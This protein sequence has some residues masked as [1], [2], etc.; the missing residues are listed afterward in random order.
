MRPA[1]DPTTSYVPTPL[2]M[3]RDLTPAQFAVALALNA[4]TKRPKRSPHVSHIELQRLQEIVGNHAGMQRGPLGPMRRDKLMSHIE[5][6]VRGN[7]LLWARREGSKLVWRWPPEDQDK[8][9]RR[10]HL[11]LGSNTCGGRDPFVR[12]PKAIAWDS[13]LT[14]SEKKVYGALHW[15]LFADGHQHWSERLTKGLT[16]LGKLTGLHRARVGE[17]LR[18]LEAKG[19]IALPPVG[20]RE[21]TEIDI[22]PLTV[23]Y[24]RLQRYSNDADLYIPMP[25]L[26]PEWEREHRLRVM[27]VRA[28]GLDLL[29]EAYWTV[30][31]TGDDFRLD[32]VSRVLEELGV[33]PEHPGTSIDGATAVEPPDEGRPHQTTRT[34][35][36]GDPG[37][38]TRRPTVPHE[39]TVLSSR[40]SP[41]T[42]VRTE[43]CSLSRATARRCNNP[44]ESDLEEPKEE[45]LDDDVEDQPE[46][47]AL[48]GEET[49]ASVHA[50]LDQWVAEDLRRQREAERRLRAHRPVL[51]HTP[52][53]APRLDDPDRP[54][55]DM[56][57]LRRLAST[58]E[59][60]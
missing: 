39:A 1:A 14:G 53:R 59:S 31:R 56:D 44:S 45:P 8:D 24:L 6:L 18:A 2:S 23:R 16:N 9:P 17:V 60:T 22:L 43:P 48:V 42:T 5:T 47:E 19:L 27:V 57:R 52:G 50:L 32:L 33:L 49:A 38:P 4:V 7:W 28:L 10:I 37:F 58:W 15:C 3:L 41:G 36:P 54:R 20:E 30:R 40:S 51:A 11:A 29:H 13:S 25:L 34:P 35:P 21:F 12:V 26:G 55:L 46:D